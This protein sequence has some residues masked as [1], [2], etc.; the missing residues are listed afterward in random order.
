[1]RTP[2]PT[3][4]RVP[5]VIPSVPAPAR[6]PAGVRNPDPAPAVPNPISVFDVNRTSSKIGRLVRNGHCLRGIGRLHLG[7]GTEA[8]VVISA[9]LEVIGADLE[10]ISADLVVGA[11]HTGINTVVSG[12]IAS[13]KQ[14]KNKHINDKFKR[15]KKQIVNVERTC[16]R[17]WI[18][19][20][21]QS[22][23]PPLP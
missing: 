22:W 16:R 7:F 9:G 20:V 1:M 15:F 13:A 17:A 4:A 14:T 2:T 11:D 10:L 6:V 23:P 18:E 12:T 5:A 21:L 19:L 3:P 8:N